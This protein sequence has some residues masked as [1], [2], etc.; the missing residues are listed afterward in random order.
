MLSYWEREHF[1][2]YDYII[3]G[4]GIVGL[5]TALSL[6]QRLPTASILI[7]ERGLL[8]TGASTRNA[9]FACI[10]SIAEMLD[11]LDHISEH[12]MLETVAMR[13][14]GLELLRDRL[15]HADIGYSADGSYELIRKDDLYVL[16]HIDNVVCKENTIHTLANNRKHILEED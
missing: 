6:R 15:R 10:G 12:R 4:G 3:V 7:L 11:D 16:D 9:G 1:L 8:P 2:H 14:K 13:Y 5:S